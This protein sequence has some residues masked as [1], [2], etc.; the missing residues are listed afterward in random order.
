MKFI[1]GSRTSLTARKEQVMKH[2][3]LLL[4]ATL[5]LSSTLYAQKVK[6]IVPGYYETNRYGTL[7]EAI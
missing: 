1:I 3:L 6:V 7:N 5:C 4:L 2:L